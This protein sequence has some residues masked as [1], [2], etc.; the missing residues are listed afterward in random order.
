MTGTA[1]PQRNAGVSPARVIDDL[2][3]LM[4]RTGDEHGAQR[5][6]FTPTWRE[7]RA[8]L[9][10]QLAEIG[11]EPQQDQVGNLWATLPGASADALL[12]GGHLD[13]VPNGGWLDGALNIMAGLEIVRRL[14]AIPERPIT[15]ELVDWADEEGARFAG[16]STFGSGVAAGIW[17]PLE[18]ADLTDADGITLRDAT[19]AFGIDLA[20]ARESQ[21]R[22][23][24]ARAYLEL[25]IEQ[26][27]VLEDLG[28]PLAAVTGTIGVERHT[29]TVT[30]QAAH[31]G[32][33]A[34]D[35][36]RDAFLAAAR[37]ALN[38][39]STAKAEGGFGTCGQV[40]LVPGIPTAVA[41]R[42]TMSVDLRHESQAV[43]SRML[44][45][46][47]SAADRIR[48]EEQV[49]AEWAPSFQVPATSF[50]PEL[51][52]L[53][54]ECVTAFTGDAHEMPSATLHDATRVAQSGI[55]TA[56]VFVQSLGGLSHAKEE[57]TRVEHLE[58]AI[59]AL[60]SLVDRT[61][62][63]VVSR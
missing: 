41:G 49:D 54:R 43:L 20:S 34:M 50:H 45:S 39:R 51:V 61:I 21:Q 35:R 7:A 24:G 4:R 8:F 42:A 19:A 30:G 18:L 1:H 56:M 22:L 33:T 3:E 60:D 44:A 58:L 38:V 36:R 48:A 31:A 2:R 47:T 16:R 28:L 55:P 17:D 40:A 29:L 52:A 14:A 5:V 59:R 12:I 57:D 53:A 15:V 32:A 10:E 27:P 11:I 13:S 6:A 9:T 23:A 46:A 62:E 25:H 37:L 26:G 63:W